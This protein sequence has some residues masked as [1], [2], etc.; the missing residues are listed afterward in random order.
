MNLRH[1]Q[2]SPTRSLQWFV[3]GQIEWGQIEI[4]LRD[5]AEIQPIRSLFSPFWKE[6]LSRCQDNCKQTKI[7]F[8][9]SQEFD[10]TSPG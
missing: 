1:E 10:S 2:L 7:N 4:A 3:G 5:I 8:Y 6:V 9:R